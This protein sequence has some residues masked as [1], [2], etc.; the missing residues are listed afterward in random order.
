MAHYTTHHVCGLVHCMDR[1]VSKE[2]IAKAAEPVWGKEIAEDLKNAYIHANA[3]NKL[4]KENDATTTA[5]LALSGGKTLAVIGHTGVCGGMKFQHSLH[6]LKDSGKSAEYEELK[7]SSEIYG[8]VGRDMED[9][10]PFVTALKEKKGDGFQALLESGL[11]R[12]IA[13]EFNVLLQL[14][15]LAAREDFKAAVE[16]NNNQ[17]TLLGGMYIP[18]EEKSEF[19]K[20]K[21]VAGALDTSFSLLE[22]HLGSEWISEYLANNNLKHEGNGKF[23]LI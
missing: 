8:W 7:A 5:M 14:A 11:F 12:E 22:Q 9:F 3:G 18:K 17:L 21:A 6:K 1:R 20:E 23:L 10:E 15:K 19:G 2:L 4:F 13:E 16:A